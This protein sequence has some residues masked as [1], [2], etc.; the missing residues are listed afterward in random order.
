MSP[1]FA[2]C[3]SLVARRTGLAPVV[4]LALALLSGAAG[5]ERA[6][7]TQPMTI[8]ADNP[9]GNVIDLN[10][11]TA[12]FKGNVVIKQGTLIIHSDRVDVS[13]D[14]DGRKVGVA[15]GGPGG[16]ATF[17]QKS[18]RPD[19][20]TEGEAQRIEYDSEANKVRFVGAGHLRVLRKDEVTNEARSGLITYDTQLETMSFEG[21]PGASAPG[22][23]H[24]M[25]A[26]PPPKGAASAAGG[27][28]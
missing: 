5:A 12:V 20:W 4:A 21:A 11:R 2:A 25:F 23:V 8:D 6:D 19:E 27:G 24:F 17:R 14:K 16:L 13:E 3:R 15:T 1:P 28:R 9:P 26:P 18:D 10:K 22:R 7:R